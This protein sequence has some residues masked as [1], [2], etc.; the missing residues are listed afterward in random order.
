MTAPLRERHGSMSTS[1]SDPLPVGAR[2]VTV[3]VEFFTGLLQSVRQFNEPA[4]PSPFDTI[5]DAGYAA[6]QALHDHFA[7]WL[8]ERGEASIGDL[9]DAHFPVVFSAFFRDL[10]WGYAEL[11]SISD[12]VMALDVSEWGEVGDTASGCLVTTGLF[13]GFFSRLAG[14]P[15]SVLEVDAPD[16]A[17][18]RGR[19]LLASVDVLE[20]VWEA[21]E[22][23]IPWEL[24]AASA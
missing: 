21:M 9:S 19:F 14:A 10:G 24:A 11:L 15:I 13:A 22:R 3:P 17:S 5:R 2:T 20:Y 1:F 4:A 18:G 16:V 23:G 12:A 7:S 8:E 6:G